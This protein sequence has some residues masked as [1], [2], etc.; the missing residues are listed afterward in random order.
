[1]L[2]GTRQDAPAQAAQV[3][4]KRG[5]RPSRHGFRRGITGSVIA[6]LAILVAL[7]GLSSR[8]SDA[9]INSEM[10]A[11]LVMASVQQSNP[12]ARNDLLLEV[13]KLAPVRVV[14]RAPDTGVSHLQAALAAPRGEDQRA[15]R[16]IAAQTPDMPSASTA[17]MPPQ[18]SLRPLPR[19]TAAFAAI[20]HETRVSSSGALAAPVAA[21]PDLAR[22]EE[23]LA[24]DVSLRP[25]LRPA[26]LQYRTVEYTR[27]WLRNVTQRTLNEQEACLA[28]AIYHEARGESIK[29]QFA[30]AE[31]ILNRVASNQFPGSIC[32]VVYQGVQ[33]GRRGGCQF[34]F[35][36]DG[37]SEAMPNR[38]AANRARRI[39]QVMVDGA[40]SGVTQGALYFHTTAVNPAWSN[41]FRQTTQIG[42][43]LFYRG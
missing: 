13:P 34:S 39:A 21:V 20:A 17:E 27:R 3:T 15:A 19:D 29:G 5:A 38:T 22:V 33:A 32:G 4:I 14:S 7:P 30:V 24:P 10:R 37:Q 8:V 42:T 26:S 18:Q 40:H 9:T 23:A 31:V 36:C 12:A 6:S 43:H 41:R 2:T 25:K 28:T 35:A 16:R 1:M 11:Q